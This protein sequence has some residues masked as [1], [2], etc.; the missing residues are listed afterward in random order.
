[1]KVMRK[2]APLAVAITAVIGAQQALADYEGG[3]AVIRFGVTMI[4]PDSDR[5]RIKRFG[6]STITDPDGIFEIDDLG[7]SFGIDDDTTGFISGTLLVADHWG[8][9]VYVPGETTHDFNLRLTGDVV[10]D[11]EDFEDEVLRATGD[12]GD[13]QMWLPSVTVQWYPVCVESWVQPYVGLGVNYSGMDDESLSS[14]A[15]NFLID[16]GYALGPRGAR[17]DIDN[18]WGITGELGIDILFGED[19]QWLV[20]FGATYMDVDTDVEVV[21]DGVDGDIRYD[22]SADIDPWVFNLGLGYKF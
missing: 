22:A 14:S 8:I 1:M 5:H 16:N 21:I 7:L 12:V 11:D 17:I 13:F 9:G 4:D 6:D 3:D 18:D 2:I 20:N 10:F 15:R 19:S